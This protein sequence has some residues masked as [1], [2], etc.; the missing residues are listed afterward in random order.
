MALTDNFVIPP[1]TALRDFRKEIDTDREA[2][3]LGILKVALQ[4]SVNASNERRTAATNLTSRQTNALTN[5]IDPRELTAPGGP[6]RI[7]E[8]VAKTRAEESA[9]RKAK[10]FASDWAGLASR[11]K[12]LERPVIKGPATRQQ[13]KAAPTKGIPDP[14]VLSALIA[15]KY[16]TGGE[17]ATTARH[18]PSGRQTGIGTRKTK[19]TF[20]TSGANVPPGIALSREGVTAAPPAAGGAI[21]DAPIAP[22]DIQTVNDIRGSLARSQKVPPSAVVFRG[23][24]VVNGERKFQWTINGREVITRAE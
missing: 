11:T 19:Q 22:K 2:A 15:N 3:N 14:A 6:G 23:D 5:L 8:A 9:D 17:Y 21:P 20:S 12:A 7:A 24:T 13:L 10:T 4:D 16:K 1:G 18:D